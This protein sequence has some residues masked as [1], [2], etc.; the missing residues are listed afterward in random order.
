M[1][2]EHLTKA[3]NLKND[4]FYTQYDDIQNEV[5]GYLEYD[6]NVFKDKVIFLPCDDPEWSNFT[7]FFAV[8]FEK[9]GLKKLISTSYAHTSK[10]LN[11]PYQQTLFEEESPQFDYDK[12]RTRGKIFTLKRGQNSK[13]IDYNDLKWKYLKGDGDFRS[14]ECIDLL[15][16][17]DIVITNPPFSLFR[18]FIAHIFKYNKKFLVIGNKNAI[19]YKNTF[20]LIKDNKIWL[21]RKNVKIFKTFDEEGE[22]FKQ[23][24]NVGWFTN[25]EHGLRHEKLKLL[26]M[27][28]NLIYDKSLTKAV[29]EAGQRSNNYNI[30]DMTT[31]MQ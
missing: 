4:E 15:K 24:G 21:G 9:F 27:E 13:K 20:S 6:P 8:N 3:K 22:K 12:S 14:Q 2:K 31:M 1:G 25:L 28:E 10:K 17:S 18:E 7:K 30:L 23:F 16:Q 11:F 5:N 26:T 29:R 19:T